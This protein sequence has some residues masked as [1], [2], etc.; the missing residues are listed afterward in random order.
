MR[1]DLVAPKNALMLF[2]VTKVR[3]FSSVKYT[4]LKMY[5]CIFFIYIYIGI[6]TTIL[7]KNDM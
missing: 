2:R 4:I 3:V 5:L 1:T 6:F 7:S